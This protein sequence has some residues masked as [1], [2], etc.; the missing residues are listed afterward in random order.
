MVATNKRRSAGASAPFDIAAQLGT[1][2]TASKPDASR[3]V[4]TLGA[5]K[6]KSRFFFVLDDTMDQHKEKYKPK[7]LIHVDADLDERAT[8]YRKEM[9]PELKSKIER[10][11]EFFLKDIAPLTMASAGGAL[12]A[13]KVVER[14]VDGKVDTTMVSSFDQMVQRAARIKLS[15]F[16]LDLFELPHSM[17]DELFPRAAQDK[18]EQRITSVLE[19]IIEKLQEQDKGM[20]V[21]SGQM[22]RLQRKE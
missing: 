16:V 3:E 5:R 12:Q 7:K 15:H 18:P 20:N 4:I 21:L 11:R 9:T 17:M 1:I 2:A 8:L 6:Y 10:I 22:K 14:Y 19:Q 13:Q